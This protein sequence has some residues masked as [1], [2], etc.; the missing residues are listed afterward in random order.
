[1]VPVQGAI[2]I[3]RSAECDLVLSDPEVSGRHCTIWIEHG[4]PWIRDLD[5]R[6]GTFVGDQPVNRAT[7]LRDG[8]TVRAGSFEATIRGVTE[9]ATAPVALALVDL[10]TGLQHAL[11]TDRFILGPDADADLRVDGCPR[12]T[13]VVHAE[14]EVWLDDEE[15]ALDVPHR[16]GAFAFLLR[17]IPTDAHHPTVE[18]GSNRYPYQV[19][20]DLNGSTGPVCVVTDPST[21]AEHVIDATNRAVLMFVLAKR[22]ADDRDS[23]VSLA[24]RGWCSDDDLIR[25]VWGKAAVVDGAG[26]LKA[27]MHRLRSEL[28][29]AGFDPWFLEKKRGYS[30]FRVAEARL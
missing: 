9:A 27:L 30:R 18:A 25:G 8:A 3:G 12:S 2:T 10:G 4:L 15:L 6:N 13:L 28:R 29:D 16:V 17:R 5:S 23:G 1:M 11:R 26:K 22:W 19:V 20:V 7:P 14:G 21:G 24:N